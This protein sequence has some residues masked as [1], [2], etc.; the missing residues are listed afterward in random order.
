MNN[1]SCG[2]FHHE[3]N[4]IGFTFL[5]IFYDFLRNLQ[6]SAKMAILFENHFCSR[7]PGKFRNLTNM[8]L[9]H[10]KHPGNFGFLAM[11]SL[12]TAA[13][14]GGSIPASSSPGLAREGGE[15]D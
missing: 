11:S 5:C 2:M 1:K 14:A 6:E 10:E 15:F 3:S 4:K 13:G 9:A 7:V 8:P 12:G